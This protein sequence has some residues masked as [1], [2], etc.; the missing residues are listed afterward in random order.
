[1]NRHTKR[2]GKEK[3]ITRGGSISKK[4]QRKKRSGKD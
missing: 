4:R 3:K 1:V 2:S